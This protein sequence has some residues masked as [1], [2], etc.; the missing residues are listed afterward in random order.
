VT[1]RECEHTAAFRGRRADDSRGEKQ[2]HFRL[3]AEADEERLRDFFASHTP[4]TI[5][6]RYGMTMREM[7][8][9]RALQLVCLDGHAELALVGLDGAPGAERIVAV[10]RYFLD[11]S[12][13]LAEIAF[14]VREQYR[15]MGIATHLLQKLAQ[16]VRANGFAG[17]TAQVLVANTAMLQVLTD[18]LGRADEI[19]SG[20]GEMTLTYRFKNVPPK[21]TPLCMS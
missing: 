12:T 5:H 3:I 21:P 16:I 7:S 1:N 2:I 9:A 19:T 10:G 20:E 8:H 17:I 18:V 13:R 6:A 4:E 15:G 14:V 11:E